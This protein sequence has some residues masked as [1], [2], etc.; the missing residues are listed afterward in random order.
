[1]DRRCRD[2]P[3][4]QG[5][6]ETVR[7]A[8]PNHDYKRWDERDM[9]ELASRAV[10]PDVVR[11]RRL[12][13]GLRSDVI[14]L[15]ILRQH[16]GVYFDTDFEVLSES[17]EG[18]FLAE[19]GFCYGDEK[20]GRP[21]NA[22]MAAPAGHPFVELYLRRIAASFRVPDDLWETVRITGPDKLA[23]CLNFW[24]SEWQASS[25]VKLGERQIGNRYAADSITAFWKEAFYPYHY[26]DGTWATF[27]PTEF[28]DALAA[29]HWEG[30]WNR[31]PATAP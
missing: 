13:L 3:R 9:E 10:M 26:K 11:D 8:F 29:H 24:T 12:P 22:M 1:M 30:G 7:R 21:S 15:E 18:V 2:G 4:L 23:E 19:S 17:A 28:P 20:S 31:E 5:Y 27:D 14:R 16:G 25:P 6:C